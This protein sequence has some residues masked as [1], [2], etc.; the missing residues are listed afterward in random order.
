MNTVTT[1]IERVRAEVAECL[2]VPDSFPL[3]VAKPDARMQERLGLA[4]QKALSRR[5][6]DKAPVSAFGELTWHTFK[7]KRHAALESAFPKEDVEARHRRQRAEVLVDATTRR[8]PRTL[9][10]A[11]PDER[12]PAL[13]IPRPRAPLLT[14]SVGWALVATGVLLVIAAH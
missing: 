5:F 8:H 2:A 4:A 3:L 14:K 13:H 6:D 11:F 7:S 1:H 10:E 9:C 12:A